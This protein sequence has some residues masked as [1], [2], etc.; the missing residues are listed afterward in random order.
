MPGQ[1]QFPEAHGEPT[2]PLPAQ[3][4]GSRADCLQSILCKV[5]G[6]WSRESWSSVLGAV[7]TDVKSLPGEHG[8]SLQGVFVGSL[9]VGK[10]QGAELL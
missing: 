6:L 2:R 1:D 3:A 9:E 4:S 8:E 10:V 7:V 5:D